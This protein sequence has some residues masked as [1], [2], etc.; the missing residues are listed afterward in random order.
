M[1]AYTPEC[2]DG[3]CSQCDAENACACPHHI[4]GDTTEDAE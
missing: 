1:S 3:F 4:D 2:Y